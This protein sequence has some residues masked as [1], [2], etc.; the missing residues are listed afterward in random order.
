[1]LGSADVFIEAVHQW[2]W[3]HW[4]PLPSLA[5]ER[6]SIVKCKL[7]KIYDSK[8]SNSILECK[9]YNL[10]NLWPQR[11]SKTWCCSTGRHF[12]ATT[13]ALHTST[14]HQTQNSWIHRNEL[15]TY[16]TKS[17]HLSMSREAYKTLMD[18]VFNCVIDTL[19]SSIWSSI[20]I[21]AV[22]FH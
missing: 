22:N 10:M 3:H 19:V 15:L 4:R 5:H 21:Y 14:Q 1:M 11:T 9:I 20:T 17:R 7:H 16:E 12:T 18:Q 8:W 6:I 2:Q 13:P